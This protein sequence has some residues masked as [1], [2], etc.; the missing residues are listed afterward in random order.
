MKSKRRHDQKRSAGLVAISAYKV[1]LAFVLTLASITLLTASHH[2]QSLE[3]FSEVSY[4]EKRLT[5]IDWL[6]DQILNLNSVTLQISEL[7]TGFYAVVMGIEAIGL[8]H[9]RAWAHKLVIVS[10]GISI[11]FEFLELIRAASLLKLAI[12]YINTAIFWYL[13]C[14]LQVRKTARIRRNP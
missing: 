9:Q 11:P 7:T 1:G 5:L 4:I 14:E 13:L 3:A 6:I 10:A 2:R 8:W 12:L